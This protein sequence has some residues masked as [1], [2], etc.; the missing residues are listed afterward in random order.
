MK[1]SMSLTGVDGFGGLVIDVFFHDNI[2]HLAIISASSHSAP[3]NALK[4]GL[5]DPRSILTGRPPAVA[6]HPRNHLGVK[7]VAF[8]IKF[9]LV[10]V[11]R[12]SGAKPAWFVSWN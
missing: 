1:L 4:D 9:V 8:T 10:G 3:D 12:A 11:R 2:M 5:K 7:L 6:E